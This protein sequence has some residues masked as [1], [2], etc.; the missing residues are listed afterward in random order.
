MKPDDTLDSRSVEIPRAPLTDLPDLELTPLSHYL[1]GEAA[2]TALKEAVAALKATAL[3]GHDILIEAFGITVWDVRYFEPHTLLLRGR[4]E[5]GRDTSV[6]A[7][8]SQLV[9]RVVYLP[10][11][12]S[13]SVIT[14]FARTTV[15]SKGK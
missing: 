13:E 3:E 1:T 9:A 2:F 14:G 11:H 5:Q 4:D 15:P 6:V 10:K 8:F 7:H 12:A